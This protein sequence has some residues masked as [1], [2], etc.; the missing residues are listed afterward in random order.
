MCVFVCV[1]GSTI[2][3]YIPPRPVYLH[4][5]CYPT[6]RKMG[7]M[8]RIDL[9]TPHFWWEGGRDGKHTRVGGVCVCV[10]VCVGEKAIKW[11]MLMWNTWDF[12]NT[13]RGSD[14]LHMPYC[15]GYTKQH[16]YEVLIFKFMLM[17]TMII[18]NCLFERKELPWIVWNSYQRHSAVAGMYTYPARRC[19]SLGEWWFPWRPTC[20]DIHHRGEV[21]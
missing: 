6:S 16:F 18:N 4:F 19:R 10:C 21:C 12:I 2:V 20:T 5:C 13:E 9:T 1:C 11:G 7:F 14:K 17:C 8:I 15:D 3:Q